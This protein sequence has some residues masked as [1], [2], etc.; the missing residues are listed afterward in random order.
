[1]RMIDVGG[2]VLRV[3]D[4]GDAGGRAP[5]VLAADAPVVLEHLIPMV[6]ALQRRRRVVA[7]E[8]PGFGFSRPHR[9]YRF[10]L[11]EQVGVL[12]GLLDAL[13]VSRAHLAFTCVNALVAA[14]LAKR[15]PERVERLTLGQLP[16]LEEYRRWAARID[17]KVAGVSLLSTPGVG[18]ALMAAAPSFVADKW[19][20]GVSGPGA[21]PAAYSRVARN[22]YQKGGTFCLAAL[23]QSMNSMTAADIGP[24][25][26]PTTFLWGAADRSHRAT[27]RDTCRE[28]APRADV[29]S[30]DDL[31]H[32]FDIEDPARVAS[33][34]LDL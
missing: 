24:L 31:G 21:E 25:S 26:I 22:V 27:K 11:P 7:L 8:M 2:N 18:Q 30:F 33:L 29:R 1:M 4:V 23:N 6:E 34:L 13:G 3:L 9:Q 5:I 14:A 16:S 32:C 28:I 12:L 20:R 10:T 19:F 17:F 15:A